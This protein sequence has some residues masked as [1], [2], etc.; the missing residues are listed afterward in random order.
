MALTA[1]SLLTGASTRE[2]T[3]NSGLIYQLILNS[4]FPGGSGKNHALRRRPSRKNRY[5]TK[6]DGIL[7]QFYKRTFEVS[8][9]KDVDSQEY[10]LPLPHIITGAIR[11]L[12]N[13]LVNIQYLGPL[14]SPAKRYYLVSSDL[15]ME[16]DPAGE[17]LSYILRELGGSS[18]LF[19]LPGATSATNGSLLSALN[20]WLHYFRTGEE[21]PSQ[22]INDEITI[23]RY[24]DIIVEFKLRSPVGS[25]THSLADSGFGYSQLL[26]I[27]VRG[28]LSKKAS[29]LVI[30]QPEVH[31][32]PSLQVRLAS[33]LVS[34]LRTGKQV[35]I[36]THSEHIVNAVRVLA[37]EDVERKLFNDVSILF[38]NS[39]QDGPEVVP[40][41]MEED[42]TF[43]DWPKEFF[44][45]A[46]SLSGRL[47]RAQRRF[48]KDL[49]KSIEVK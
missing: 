18:V 23:S 34:L 32:N 14:R 16:M 49:S 42:G 38:L 7:P 15:N 24:Q 22:A 47:L 13:S 33:F 26:P 39:A 20:A 35:L 9:S 1:R 29:T 37:A 44:G 5:E 41:H 27:L 48:R 4:N 8:R 31:L 6:L 10:T 40:L 12:E 3:A 46:I 2:T 17:L 45:E 43:P 21:V 28:L 36:E 11:D 19:T 25:K 30:E